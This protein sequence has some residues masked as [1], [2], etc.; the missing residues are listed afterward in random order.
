MILTSIRMRITEQDGAPK[1][2][3][4]VNNGPIP[5]EENK[6][7][8]DPQKGGQVDIKEKASQQAI[9]VKEGHWVWEGVVRVLEVDLFK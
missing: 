7:I 6:V 9:E 3:P 5:E 4:V 8:I 1:P 2:T